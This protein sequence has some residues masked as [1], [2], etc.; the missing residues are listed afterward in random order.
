M[1]TDQPA[2]DSEDLHWEFSPADVPFGAFLLYLPVVFLGGH[3]GLLAL[4]GVALVPAVLSDPRLLGLAVLF[5]LVG[6]P[7]SLLYLWPMLRDPDQ[8]PDPGRHGWLEFLSVPGLVVASIIGTVLLVGGTRLFGA[9]IRLACVVVFGFVPLPL[10]GLF[11]TEGSVDGD[12]GTLTFGYRTVDVTLL[13]R[14]RRH[15]FGDIT[16]WWLSYVAGAG[17]FGKPRLVVVPAAVAEEVL[18]VLRTGIEADPGVSRR[19]TDPVAR[20]VLGGL[21]VAFLGTAMASL[22]FL[23]GPARVFVAGATAALGVLFAAAAYYVA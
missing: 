3:V 19:E 22:A 16:V 5:L 8:R 17:G 20:A 7:F 2:P 1:V 23:G 21:A 13:A 10:L 14:V 15:R 4:V 9:W 12:A 6:G 11:A 18:A